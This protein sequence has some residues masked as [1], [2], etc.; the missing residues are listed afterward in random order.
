MEYLRWFVLTCCAVAIN[1]QSPPC[2]LSTSICS[3]PNTNQNCSNLEL[4]RVPC[5]PCESQTIDLSTNSIDRLH[6]DTFRF[7]EQCFQK[8]S[9]PLEELDLSD[10]VLMEVERD[11]F[12]PLL[13][14][15]RLFLSHNKLDTLL[16]HV[17]PPHYGLKE[18]R[19]DDNLLT[20][21]PPLHRTHDLQSL[22]LRGN[23]IQELSNEVFASAFRLQYLDL[24]LN[25]IESISKY[26]FSNLTQLQKLDLDGNMIATLPDYTFYF[27]PSMTALTMVDHPLTHIRTE[28][29]NFSSSDPSSLTELNLSD[30]DISMIE[31]DSFMALQLLEILSLANNE[32]IV[33]RRRMFTNL[34]RINNLDLSHNKL[35]DILPSVFMFI[36]TLESLYLGSNRLT[37]ISP[38]AFK[39]IEDL[40]NLSLENNLLDNVGDFL[41]ALPVLR[42]INLADNSIA[43]LT[44]DAFVGN[45]KLEEIDLS[46]NRLTRVPHAILESNSNLKNSLV[47]L[48][49]RGNLISMV[50]SESFGSL[51]YLETLDLSSNAV[52]V[53]EPNSFI[54]LPRL[55]TLKLNGN[56][57]TT[58]HK[59][60]IDSNHMLNNIYIQDNHWMCDCDVIE[61]WQ[62]L[63]TSKVSL[64]FTV[65]IMCRVPA[66]LDKRKLSE[67]ST[68][69]TY[70]CPSV[71][72]VSELSLHIIIAA[73]IGFVLLIVIIAL[74]VV[75][76]HYKNKGR[77]EEQPPAPIPT[78][79]YDDGL[80]LTPSVAGSQS[81]IS[82]EESHKYDVP[83]TPGVAG[84]QSNIDRDESLKYAVPYAYPILPKPDEASSDQRP[85]TPTKPRLYKT[86]NNQKINTEYDDDGVL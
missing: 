30:G 31:D 44:D 41:Y 71:G 49:L 58:M 65:E 73:S 42:S 62:H 36:G 21:V 54:D 50:D 24:S 78:I 20:Q 16:A 81:N 6:D 4:T 10:N 13:R 34:I 57:L 66:T 80:Y 26:T 43:N 5:F 11:C 33:L 23:M 39:G 8:G 22:S 61:L 77:K 25:K 12:E 40:H 32:L 86:N 56:K 51:A 60:A 45:S 46:N 3:G 19:L 72:G 74:V 2:E 1:G 27:L 7:L 17:F 48:G 83:L 38:E 70:D 53:V 85:P 67:V 28:A 18:L 29:F 84:S 9:G 35:D 37:Q 52:E 55:R 82:R 75:V 59:A 76:L 64:N 14:L 79:I 63:N 47:Y 68:D 15:Q 69:E